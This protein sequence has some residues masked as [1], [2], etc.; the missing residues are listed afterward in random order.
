MKTIAIASILSLLCLA[1]S[2]CFALIG[3]EVVPKERAEKEF[4]AQMRT[5]AVGTNQVEVWFA[6]TPKG[7]LQTFSSVEVKGSAGEPIP[8]STTAAPSTQPPDAVVIHFKTV[9]AHLSKGK[10]RV[11]YKISSGFP[12]YDAVEFN[13][14]D[15]INSVADRK[16]V[17]VQVPGKDGTLNPMTGRDAILY[18]AI[19]NDTDRLRLLLAEGHDI[20]SAIGDQGLTLLHHAAFQGHLKVAELLLQSGADINARN[21]MGRTALD[22]ATA[23]GQTEMAKM[24]RGYAP[25]QK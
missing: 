23:N 16:A 3:I 22:I 21:A 7:K 15:F 2:P 4:G 13:L 8:F 1:S 19:V 12:P 6:F 10:L 20:K 17:V 24:L 25:K 18:C 9:P 5:R 11:F 14:A